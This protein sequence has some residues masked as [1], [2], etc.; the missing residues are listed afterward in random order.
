MG[1]WHHLPRGH[2]H[3]WVAWLWLALVPASRPEE[4]PERSSTR[5]E[6][7]ILLEQKS[8][9]LVGAFKRHPFFSFYPTAVIPSLA[10]TGSVRE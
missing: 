5:N 6:I 9:I 8:L 7:Q 4:E 3:G 10:P 1:V 2:G